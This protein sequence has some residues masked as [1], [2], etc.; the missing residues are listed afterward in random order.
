[1]QAASTEGSG[2]IEAPAFA[3]IEAGA[4]R[5]Q[6]LVDL[7]AREDLDQM[8]SPRLR[9]WMEAVAAEVRLAQT[10]LAPS[11]PLQRSLG[12]I[13]RQFTAVAASRNPGY[14][15][16]LSLADKRD[17]KLVAAC[18]WKDV[19]R[20]DADA[21]RGPSVRSR[22]REARRPK[23]D[24]PASEP[25]TDPDPTAFRDLREHMAGRTILVVGG[26]RVP[27]TL[28]AIADMTGLKFDWCAAHGRNP[29]ATDTIC[30]RVRG[31]SVA[32]ILLIHGLIGH[33]IWDKVVAA[34][35]SRGIPY[36]SCRMSGSA[37]VLGA[38]KALE[39]RV[40]QGSEQAAE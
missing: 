12:A 23:K 9:P 13:I 27:E 40:P 19:A 2:E 30:D 32:A 14:V 34:C 3:A 11:D 38:L 35:R 8:P 22:S 18:A 24:S 7:I 6:D 21:E 29:R 20:Y 25:G 39:H 28:Q 17:W 16:G 15:R 37:Q 10:Q 4:R 1:M 31:S 5:A 33:A 26:E 36:S